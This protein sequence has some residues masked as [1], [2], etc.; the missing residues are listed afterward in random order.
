MLGRI[1]PRGYLYRCSSLGRATL[2]TN[3]GTNT[4]S[5]TR[6]VPRRAVLYVPGSSEKML[7]KVPQIQVDCLV[8]EMEDG[9]AASAKA[10]ARVNIRKY[11]D[12][13]PSKGIHKCLELGVRVNSVASQLIYDD[14][15]ELAKSPN[16]PEAFMVPKV[17]SIE[18]LA[19]IF[20]VFRSTYG[21]K[22]IASADSRLVI[23]IESARALLNMPRILNAA[24]NLNKS[25]GFFK[26]DAVVFGSDDF[27]ADIG[28]TR[29]KEGSENIYA[30]QR[31]V[32]CCKAF[33]L[34]AIDSVYIDIKNKEG[35]KTQ[36]EQGRTWGFDGKQVIHPSQIEVVQNAFLP[37]AEKVEWARELMKEFVEHEKAGTGAFTFRG[38]MIDRPLLLQAMNV[39]KMVERVS[40]GR[41]Q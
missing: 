5:R 22:R 37:S 4:K 27:C 16:M 28:A 9:V 30:R 31:F 40:K 13:L 29:T 39:V 7:K 32:T 33:S 11:L 35:L 38:H 20:D 10:E 36:C 15:K 8:L 41:G 2:C 23:W 26:I 1:L 24:V 6:Y 12:E 17:D 19:S 21:D 34:Q 25:A 14:V 18:D 3:S